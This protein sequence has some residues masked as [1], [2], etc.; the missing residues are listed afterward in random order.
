MIFIVNLTKIFR[1]KDLL[2]VYRFLCNI[3]FQNNY[4]FILHF[5][6]IFVTSQAK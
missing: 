1:K 6:Q 3:Q 2:C 5:A 4:L